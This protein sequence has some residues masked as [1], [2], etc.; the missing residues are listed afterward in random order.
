MPMTEW[1]LKKW[2][3]T[4]NDRNV[5]RV[6]IDPAL[7]AGGRGTLG[8]MLFLPYRGKA[9]RLAKIAHSIVKPLLK[10]LHEAGNNIRNGDKCCMNYPK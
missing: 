8:P 1:W 5:A 9:R 7:V 10:R 2:S 6:Q 4:G 3:P